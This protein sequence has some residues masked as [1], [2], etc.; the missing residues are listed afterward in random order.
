MKISFAPSADTK[1]IINVLLDIFERRAD[2]VSTR[3]IK[4]KLREI[5]LPAY[6]SQQDPEPRM[7]ANQQLQSLTD[8]NLIQLKWLAGEEHHL[9]ESVTLI[10]AHELYSLLHRIPISKQRSQLESF[11]LADKFR[12]SSDDWRARALNYIL[13][14]I[15]AGKSPSPFSLSASDF[16]A[17]LLAAL[18]ALSTLQAETPQRV[19]SVHVFNDTKRFDYL[20]PALIRLARPANPE[21]KLLTNED[22]L[23][24]LNLVANPG[25]IHLSGNWQ[26]TTVDGEVLS[27]NGFSPS[28]GFPAAQISSIQTVSVHADSVLCIENL[29]SFHEFIRATSHSPHPLPFAIICLMGNPSP[30]IRRLLRLIP[31][32]TKIHLWSDMD[33]GGFNILSQLRKQVSMHAEPFLMD[34]STFE[35]HAALS[36]PLTQADIRNLKRLAFNPNLRDVQSVIEYLL[37]RGLKLEQE[38]I[39][40]SQLIM[41]APNT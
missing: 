7:I 13:D 27:L 4:V 36:R 23:R 17:D 41:A 14:K 20:R 22:L 40:Q 34:I 25:Y 28:I 16:N 1:V 33:Y 3:V 26:L 5:N 2:S 19:F 31:E 24:E 15:R 8:L 10:T 11:L 35:K 39:D 18:L 21:W 9:L 37:S 6:F 38:A 29:T 12:F 32:E 30:A